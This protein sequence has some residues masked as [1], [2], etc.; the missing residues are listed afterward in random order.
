MKK[1]WKSLFD[2]NL[3][4]FSAKELTVS[5]VKNVYLYDF[6]TEELLHGWTGRFL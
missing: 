1:P 4:F 5:N 2:H 3:L 6:L